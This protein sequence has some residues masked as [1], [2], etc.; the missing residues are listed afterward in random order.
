LP[1]QTGDGPLRVLAIGQ[2]NE[3]KSPGLAGDSIA[4]YDD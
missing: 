2:F 4:N 3:T 1:V